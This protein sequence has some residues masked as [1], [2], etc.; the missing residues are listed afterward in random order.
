MLK[1]YLAFPWL[2]ILL[3]GM[4]LAAFA[5]QAVAVEKPVVIYD[6]ETDKLS[7]KTE[8]TPLKELLARIGLLSGV[9][10]LM[11]P[12]AERPVSVR[13]KEQPLERGLKQI[14]TSHDLSYAMIYEHKEGQ[15]P[16]SEEPLLIAMK[17]VPNG[18]GA[19][20]N[21]KLVPVVDVNGEAVI[22]SFARRP[23]KEGQT[24]PSIFGYA[25]KR[26]QARLERMSPE[27]RKQLEAKM[28]ERQER[29]A[30]RL[31]K[32][33]EKRAKREARQTEK[34]AERQAAEDELK[35]SNPELYEKRRQ[36]R[37]ELRQQ[38]AEE[39]MM[40]NTIEDTE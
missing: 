26:W 15:D 25:E 16:S 11:D 35:E 24:L 10:F 36:Q 13:L 27:K 40:E 14:M 17:V 37:E 34:K 20:S 23:P 29:D 9:A 30:A 1:W 18:T 22:R 33:K 5:G 3:C 6:K 4:V 28:L 8:N 21:A 12:A 32:R 31:E 19:G 39:R 7:V 2:R 38:L